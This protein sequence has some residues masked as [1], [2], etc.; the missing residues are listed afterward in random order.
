MTSSRP[1]PN[2]SAT[3]TA[4][5]SKTSASPVV[6]SSAATAAV[7]CRPGHDEQEVGQAVQVADDLAVLSA[8]PDDLPPDA[9]ENFNDLL[10][11]RFRFGFKMKF[12]SG[13][14]AAAAG[15]CLEHDRI[16]DLFRDLERLVDLHAVLTRR[17]GRR[18]HLGAHHVELAGAGEGRLPGQHVIERAAERVD[19]GAVVEGGS[20]GL[21]G[22]EVVDRAEDLP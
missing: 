1:V 21:F 9:E 7:V 2:R 6:S 4:R 12:G 14:T 18:L 8:D 16:T 20:E 11:R 22:S 19:V 5:P 10:W 17:L 15:G 3:A 13:W